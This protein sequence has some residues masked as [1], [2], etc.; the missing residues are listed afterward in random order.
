MP[1]P[2]LCT[3]LAAALLLSN[4]DDSEARRH[5][6]SHRS[7]YAA[8]HVIKK[9]RAKRPAPAKKRETPQQFCEVSADGKRL[10]IYYP[11]NSWTI[12][13]TYL[14]CLKDFYR[15]HS[16]AQ[17]WL[18][19]G[20][21]DI[22]GSADWN[23]TLGKNRAEGIEGYLH[24]WGTHGDIS[25]V[26][27]GASKPA[28]VGNTAADY[29]RNRRGI[30]TAEGEI[31]TEA[32]TRLSEEKDVGAYV[33]DASSSMD[34]LADDG[35]RS[36]W[37]VVAGFTYPLEADKYVF[38]SN[39]EGRNVR[40][41]PSLNGIRP[42]GGTPLWESVHHV[43]NGAKQYKKIVVFTDGEDN[44]RHDPLLE[45]VIRVGKAKGTRISIAGVGVYT[46]EIRDQ[47][48]RVAS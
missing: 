3:L 34:S 41:V 37:N 23:D 26:S 48:I 21:A 14:D 30:V 43:L 13:R 40:L 24:R 39:G 1:K 33:L 46:R 10:T 32:L 17:R 12:N 36:K 2:T 28:A 5:R 25:T 19:E 6:P 38:N 45:E 20:H 22:R 44:D 47:L 9:S 11:T 42:E 16:S 18:V 15:S 4:S 27:Y 29:Q 7:S 8:Q 35:R 31:I